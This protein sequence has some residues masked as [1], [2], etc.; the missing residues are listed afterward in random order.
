MQLLHALDAELHPRHPQ[1]VLIVAQA[2]DAVLDVGLLQKDRVA[3]L[4]TARGLVLQTGGNVT[5]GIFRGDE[6]AVRLRKGLV[7]RSRAGDEVRFQQRSLGLDVLARLDENLVD[8]SRGMTDLEVAVPEKIEDLVDEM[9]LQRLHDCG[10][11]LRWEEEH[12]IDVALRTQLVAA[13]AAERDQAD[14]GGQV[15][16]SSAIG[17][18]G[19]VEETGQHDV[20][21]RGAGLGH[22]EPG[23][24]GIVMHA[25]HRALQPQEGLAGR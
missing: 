9:F 17:L 14:R 16:V 11:G 20:D 24:A 3:I 22:L 10:P 18:N 21:H 19:I 15:F 25:D 5:L 4:R 13:V 8:G 23:L 7:K 1:R 6:I 12:H 2:A